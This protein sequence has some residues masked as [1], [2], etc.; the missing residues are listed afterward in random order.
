MG[1]PVPLDRGYDGRAPPSGRRRRAAWSTRFGTSVRAIVDTNV[2]ISGRSQRPAPHGRST[3]RRRPASR[4]SFSLDELRAYNRAWLNPRQA[5]GGPTADSD[6]DLLVILGASE[7][8]RLSPCAGVYRSLRRLRLPI[9]VRGAHARR[10]HGEPP[11][12]RPPGAPGAGSRACP[13]WMRARAAPR[14]CVRRT[15]CIRT[16]AA[17]RHRCLSLPTGSGEGLAGISDPARHPVSQGPPVG[18]PVRRMR[19]HRSP[20]R[21]V[22]RGGSDIDPLRDG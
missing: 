17:A 15:V 11:G 16:A 3:H 5:W 1:P 8:P 2:L 4:R 7:Q 12:S 10:G 13:P 19:A 6:I 20:V 21:R 9:E 14:L 22:G 18:S